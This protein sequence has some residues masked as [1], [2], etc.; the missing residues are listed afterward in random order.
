MSKS[1]SC[2]CFKTDR[3]RTFSSS[4]NARKIRT[5]SGIEIHSH[6]S[7]SVVLSFLTFLELDTGISRHSVNE[8]LSDLSTKI[9]NY[10]LF[11]THKKTISSLYPSKHLIRIKSQVF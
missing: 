2:V 4:Q 7:R 1:V 11:K 5:W 8:T 10:M 6:C 9:R 3:G